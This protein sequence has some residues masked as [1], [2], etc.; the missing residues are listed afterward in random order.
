MMKSLPFILAQVCTHS[1]V[2]AY[3][4]TY[5]EDVWKIRG[6]ASPR[7]FS[8]STHKH[9]VILLVTLLVCSCILDENQR[10]HFQN[11]KVSTAFLMQWPDCMQIRCKIE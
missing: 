5:Q 1:A 9:K 4:H 10:T 7:N 2:R 6:I 8:R 11:S 3:L